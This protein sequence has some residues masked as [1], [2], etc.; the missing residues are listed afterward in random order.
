[1][2]QRWIDR[3]ARVA[4][5]R[6]RLAVPEERKGGS[7]TERGRTIV[8]LPDKFPRFQRSRRAPRPRFSQRVPAGTARAQRSPMHAIFFSLKRAFQ[9]S[10]QTMR[11]CLATL[12]LTAARFDMLT[13]IEQQQARPILQSELRLVLGVSRATVSR[14]LHSIEELGLVLRR[15]SPHDARQ[16]EI[17]LTRKGLI[18]LKRAVLWLVR[19]GAARFALES[20]LVPKWYSE[21]ACFLEVSALDDALSRLRYGFRDR[22]TLYYAWHPDD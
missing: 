17:S 8:S 1:M 3:R 7:V 21:S 9:S 4:R 5:M 18:A 14:M 11:H 20:A 6:G 10:L 19:T 15:K 16:R 13:A 2:S 12:G 22:A